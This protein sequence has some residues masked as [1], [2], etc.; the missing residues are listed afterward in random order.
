MTDTAHCKQYTK[1]QNTSL[2]PSESDRRADRAKFA[3]TI[4]IIVQRD[5]LLLQSRQNHSQVDD[6]AQR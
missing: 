6:A 1:L 5:V 4:S 3:R 2:E